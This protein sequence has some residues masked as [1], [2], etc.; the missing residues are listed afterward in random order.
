MWPNGPLGCDKCWSSVG[1]KPGSLKQ[2]GK[3]WVSWVSWLCSQR[4]AP[5]G[6]DWNVHLDLSNMKHRRF[7][8]EFSRNFR[9]V[10]KPTL[11]LS[12]FT[13]PGSLSLLF[14]STRFTFSTLLNIPTFLLIINVNFLFTK[15]A[16]KI[17]LIL[18]PSNLYVHINFRGY[19]PMKPKFYGIVL[20]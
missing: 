9:N 3:Q 2:L 15:S 6:A 12:K 16:R 20:L 5:R 4:E 18:M 1:F 8:K 19:P 14:D 10:T 11:T 13:I 17:S 7:S